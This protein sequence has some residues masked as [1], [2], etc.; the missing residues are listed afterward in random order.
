M[1]KVILTAALTTLL[2]IVSQGA[3]DLSHIFIT[4]STNKPAL[5]YKAGEEMI[6]TFKAEMGKTSPKGYFLSY[7]RKGD[8]GVT[9]KGKVP[10]SEILTVKTSLD[11][12]GFVSVNVFLVDEKGKDFIS[13]VKSLPGET[14]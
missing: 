3:E 5:S 12:R 14:R 8:D 6:Y 11:R 7:E 1:K 2:S 10:A 13:K 4:G 9:F